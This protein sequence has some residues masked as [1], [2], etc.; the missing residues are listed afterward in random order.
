MVFPPH[1]VRGRNGP[2]KQ[3]SF[4]TAC[5]FIKMKAF[6]EKAKIPEIIIDH[7]V[8]RIIYEK[9][10]FTWILNPRLGNKVSSIKVDGSSLK[11]TSIIEN[12]TCHVGATAFA[13]FSEY[14]RTREK[15][16]LSDKLFEIATRAVSDDRTKRQQSIRQFK[17]EWEAAQ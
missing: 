10:T 17:T 12:A 2:I 5:H 15:W 14:N 8:D 16:Q 11:K 6:D 7:Y 4:S 13:R 9:G 3:L 1:F